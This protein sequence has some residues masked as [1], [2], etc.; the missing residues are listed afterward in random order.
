M[1]PLR[2]S[3]PSSTTPFVNYSMIAVCIAVFAWQHSSGEAESVLRFGMVP[4]RVS[5]PDQDILVK[6]P[7]VVETSLGRREIVQAVKL[8]KASVPEWATLLTCV[9]LHGGLMHLAGNLWFLHI[10]GDNVEDR[11]GHLGYFVF[12]IV[13]GLAASTIH[14]L[15]SPESTVPTIGA[16][17]AI[18]GVM[19]AYMLLYPRSRVESI[20][21]IFFILQIIVIPAPIFLGI[22]FVMQLAN[23][24]FAMGDVSA[25]GVAWWAHIGGFVAG[26]IIAWFLRNGGATRPQVTVIRPASEQ[27]IYYRR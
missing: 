12:Y 19:G 25:G 4:A 2:D 23:G 15:S 21:P 8:K 10:F 3:I 6:E 13:C 18:A 22:W 20:V 14:Y 9:F 1:I 26:F 7:I 5:H 11:L 27:R 17:G 16:S 24:T